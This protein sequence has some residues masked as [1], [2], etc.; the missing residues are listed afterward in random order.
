MNTFFRYGWKGA[1]TYPVWK[2]VYTYVLLHSDQ[3]QASLESKL[4]EFVRHF[5]KAYPTQEEIYH[6]QPLRNIHLYS[7]RDDEM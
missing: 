7:H 3:T 4:P 1:S 6:L 5:L 2:A